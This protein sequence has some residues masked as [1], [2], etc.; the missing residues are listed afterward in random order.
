MAGIDMDTNETNKD[1]RTPR[2]RSP[3]HPSE[4]HRLAH[5]HSRIICSRIAAMPAEGGLNGSP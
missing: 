1:I 5:P 4:P 3:R 2:N